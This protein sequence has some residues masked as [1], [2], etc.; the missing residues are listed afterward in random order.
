LLPST[1]SIAALELIP[2]R[3]T[4]PITSEDR[5]SCAEDE[6]ALPAIVLPWSLVVD[7]GSSVVRLAD[8]GL[9]QGPV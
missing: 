6:D 5:S 3:A 1:C 9:F 2:L 4:A 7:A 8:S